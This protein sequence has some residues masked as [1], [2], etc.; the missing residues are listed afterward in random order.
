MK[1]RPYVLRSYFDTQ[2]LLAE[3][4]GRMTHAYRQ[5]FMGHKGDIEAR[6]TTNKHRLGDAVIRDMRDAYVRSQA[7]LSPF[8]RE[9]GEKDR[10]ETLLEMWREQAKLYGID[11]VKIRIEKQRARKGAGAA[12]SDPADLE[13]D[14]IKEAIRRTVR[15]AAASM[16][17]PGPA[18]ADAY[19]SRLVDCEADLLSCVRQGWD[20]V[21]ELSQGRILLRRGTGTAAGV[22]QHPGQ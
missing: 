15:P 22:P 13:M 12:S 4:Q 18:G 2:L 11:P 14:A 17:M 8:E 6:Y 9:E 10:R 3:S 5:F 21:R 16:R 7:M 19:E 20:V 1:G